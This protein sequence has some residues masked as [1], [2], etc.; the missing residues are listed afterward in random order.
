MAVLFNFAGVIVGYKALFY[1]LRVLYRLSHSN[2][3]IYRCIYFRTPTPVQKNHRSVSPIPQ[4]V[5]SHTDIDNRAVLWY[6]MSINFGRLM[7]E[8]KRDSRVL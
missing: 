2:P 6:H 3:L 5:L 7:H 8:Q 1:R 4:A